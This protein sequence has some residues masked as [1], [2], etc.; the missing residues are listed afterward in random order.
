MGEKAWDFEV[1]Q[2]PICHLLAVWS[3]TF[4]VLIS[5]QYSKDNKRCLYNSTAIRVKCLFS[6]QHFP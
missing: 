3:L 1:D 4:W 6:I 2:G 5:H